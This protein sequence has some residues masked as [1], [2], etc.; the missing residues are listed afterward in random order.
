MKNAKKMLIFDCFFAVFQAE[1]FGKLSAL[2]F[3][4]FLDQFKAPGTKIR[5]ISSHFSVCFQLFDYK[6]YENPTFSFYS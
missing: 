4:I 1:D 2:A 6:K 5:Q 3:R